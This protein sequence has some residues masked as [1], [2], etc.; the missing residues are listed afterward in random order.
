MLAAEPLEGWLEHCT[1]NSGSLDRP[2]VVAGGR[3]NVND[4]NPSQRIDKAAFPPN[5]RGQFGHAGR[6][7]L[8]AS[9]KTR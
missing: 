1:L 8:K 6:N 7:I 4:P 2:E 3:T 9:R 5:Q